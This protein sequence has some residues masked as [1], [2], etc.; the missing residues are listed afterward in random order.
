M[1]LCELRHLVAGA[2][3]FRADPFVSTIHDVGVRDGLVHIGAG[4]YANGCPLVSRTRWM[5][6]FLPPGDVKR[7]IEDCPIEHDS[8]SGRLVPDCALGVTLICVEA[9]TAEIDILDAAAGWTNAQVLVAELT[10]PA[11]VVDDIGRRP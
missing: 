8:L 7:L 9:P 3:Q 2:H 5:A 4:L 10:R 1:N 6:T 11:T